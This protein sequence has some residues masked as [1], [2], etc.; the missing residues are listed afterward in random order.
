MTDLFQPSY[1]LTTSL[2]SKPTLTDHQAGL[3]GAIN[4]SS[5]LL[6]LQRLPLTRSHLKSRLGST[7]KKMGDKASEVTDGGVTDREGTL[8]P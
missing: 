2:S 3:G 5:W 8:P 7:E 6:D 1:L 4:L